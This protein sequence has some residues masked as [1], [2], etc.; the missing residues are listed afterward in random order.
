MNVLETLLNGHN[1]KMQK[2]NIHASVQAKHK[3]NVLVYSPCTNLGEVN[4]IKMLKHDTC[5]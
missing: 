3:E 1:L 5:P 4:A 2:Q